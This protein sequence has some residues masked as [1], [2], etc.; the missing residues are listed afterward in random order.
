MEPTV[1]CVNQMALVNSYYQGLL[2]LRADSVQLPRGAYTPPPRA[3]TS[4]STSASARR[5]RQRATARRRRAERLDTLRAEGK[6]VPLPAV[7]REALERAVAHFGRKRFDL[8]AFVPSFVANCVAVSGAPPADDVVHSLPELFLRT[9]LDDGQLHCN[10]TD[11]LHVATVD[12]V[13]VLVPAGSS[14][15]QRD[16]RE[17]GCIELLERYKLVVLDPPWHNKSVAR[18]KRYHTFDHTELVRVDVP[19]LA[20]SVECILAIWVTNRPRYMTYLREQALPSWGFTF[21]ACWY[22]LKLGTNGELVVPLDSTHR[23]P[24]ETLVVAYRGQDVEH[25]Q[26]LR[27]RLG[28]QTRIV[29]SIPLR[30]SWK[31]PPE[32]FFDN[33]MVAESDKKVEL[34]AREL[35]SNWTSVGNE[36]LKFQAASLYQPVPP[37]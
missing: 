35:R 32:S 5:Q 8:R 1:S 7:V 18:G 26:L 14:F 12:G 9:V 25:E 31:P 4:L 23:L 2:R 24:V 10:R 17:L 29:L 37:L 13:Q 36:V 30:H 28:T 21:H 27:K 20:D 15:A 34:F 19:R 33:D 6:F 3:P 22:W 11:R 16:V